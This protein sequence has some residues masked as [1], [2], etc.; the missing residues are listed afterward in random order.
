MIARLVELSVR[1]RF[2]M[3][4]LFAAVAAFGFYNLTKL[5]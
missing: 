4:F 3:V 5:P 1:N 2:L